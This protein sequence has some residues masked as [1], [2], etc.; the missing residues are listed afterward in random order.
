[1][2]LPL[3][4]GN[5][6]SRTPYAGAAMDEHRFSK[7]LVSFPNLFEVVIGQRAR[8]CAPSWVTG[9]VCAATAPAMVSSTHVDAMSAAD[10]K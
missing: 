1:M 6:F 4:E 8:R 7:P 9:T 2:Q 5:G 3:D 10:E